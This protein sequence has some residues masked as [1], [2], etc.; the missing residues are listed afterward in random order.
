[1]N[2]SVES[3]LISLEMHSKELNLLIKQD[4]YQDSDHMYENVVAMAKFCIAYME[5]RIDK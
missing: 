3:W 5:A 4:R 1:M 2:D